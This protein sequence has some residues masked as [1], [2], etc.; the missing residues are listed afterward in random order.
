MDDDYDHVAALDK[1]LAL[2]VKFDLKTVVPPE[3]QQG[4]RKLACKQKESSALLSSMMLGIGKSI[5]IKFKEKCVDEEE[6]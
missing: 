3:N 1:A 4:L 6:L 5:G 2:S